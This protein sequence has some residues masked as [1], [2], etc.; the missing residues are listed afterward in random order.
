MR[1]IRPNLR[2]CT[3]ADPTREWALD[4]KRPGSSRVGPAARTPR[5]RALLR[6]D[7]GAVGDAREHS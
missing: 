2:A 4:V 6:R 3:R 5:W 1:S 7:P